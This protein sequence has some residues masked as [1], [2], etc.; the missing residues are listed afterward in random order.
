[1]QKFLLILLMAIL[2]GPARADEDIRDSN[3]KPPPAQRERDDR[4]PPVLPGEDIRIGSG[5]KMK[6]WTTAGPVPVAEPPEPWKNGG[7]RGKGRA[8]AEDISVIID[9]RRTPPPAKRREETEP[10]QGA[11]QP[12]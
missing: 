8:A 1:M 11:L 4:L 3:R 9:G 10:S 5:R 7:R 12:Q 2:T 6:V